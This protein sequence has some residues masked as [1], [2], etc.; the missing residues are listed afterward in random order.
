MA[1]KSEVCCD[2]TPSD[3]GCQTNV[4]V[5]EGFIESFVSDD[6]S[7]DLETLSDTAVPLSLE[8]FLL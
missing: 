5:P 8:E 3:L 7:Y 4:L 1:I 6:S 2:M